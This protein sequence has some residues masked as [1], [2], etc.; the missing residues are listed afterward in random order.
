MNSTKITSNNNESTEKLYLSICEDI[1]ITSDEANDAL[2]K[3]KNWYKDW[4]KL[5]RFDDNKGDISESATVSSSKEC[6]VNNILSTVIEEEEEE[7]ESNDNI[8]FTNI[9]NNDIISKIKFKL[10][11][12]LRKNG[13]DATTS[14]FLYNLSM[15]TEAYK[16]GQSLGEIH[17]NKSIDNPSKGIW[18]TLSKPNFKECLGR[19]PTTGEYMYA[20]G[21][22]SFDMFPRGDLTCSVRGTFNMVE[23][24]QDGLNT[25]GLIV[26][27]SLKQED[28]H[29]IMTYNIS[30]PF[31]IED[32][33]LHGILT[34][35]GYMYPDPSIPNRYS[36]WFT[37]GVLEP[38]VYRHQKNNNNND[39]GKMN[40]DEQAEII[41]NEWKNIFSDMN[42]TLSEK[43]KCLAA[44]LFLGV[45]TPEVMEDDGSMEY[46][47]MKPL[48]AHCD[49]LYLDENLRIIKGNLGTIYVFY[50][51]S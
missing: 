23:N 37:R 30:V 49:V 26:P 43:A 35:Y 9:S 4:W 41:E 16:K 6:V 14:I 8:P 44:R 22:M 50:R 32:T 36:V 20:L 38:D 12:E 29:G 3:T 45:C 1:G 17:N 5:E 2:T 28:L 34:N 21:R 39:E 33:N 18:A 31:R 42:R 40:L 13:G 47:F 19:H 7:E 51:I 48:R 10:L 27:K 46:I 15:L 11:Q 25:E 24:V